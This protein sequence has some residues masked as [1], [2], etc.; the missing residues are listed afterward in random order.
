MQFAAPDSNSAIRDIA[1]NV[2]VSGS[3]GSITS[4]LRAPDKLHSDQIAPQNGANQ[5]TNQQTNAYVQ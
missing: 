2:H 3:N 5:P 1:K 4:S